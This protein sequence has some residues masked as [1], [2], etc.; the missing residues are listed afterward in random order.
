MYCKQHMDGRHTIYSIDQTEQRS[1]ITAEG[2]YSWEYIV[3]LNVSCYGCILNFFLLIFFT[4]SICLILTV[5]L[6]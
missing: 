3:F 2:F 5:D 6:L 1:S 4:S